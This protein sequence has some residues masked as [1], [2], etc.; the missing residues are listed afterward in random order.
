[1]VK[2]DEHPVVMALEAALRALDVVDGDLKNNRPPAADINKYLE[3]IDRVEDACNQA[4]PMPIPAAA[5]EPGADL[6]VVARDEIKAALDGLA[7][8]EQKRRDMLD[9]ADLVEAAVNDDDA[10]VL[11]AAPM[12][13][14]PPPPPAS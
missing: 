7:A 13:V 2:P 1:M 9:M 11:G 4:P 5:L 3:A 8:A 6:D 10:G 14:A 12:D